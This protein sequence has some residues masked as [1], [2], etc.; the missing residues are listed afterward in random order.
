MKDVELR[1][2]AELMK[3][4]RRNDREL[5]KAIGAS[6]PTVSRTIA[7]LE[8]EGVLKEYTVIPDFAKLG[9]QIMAFTFFNLRKSL[10]PA[11]V[12]E[13]RK[14]AKDDMRAAPSE[15]VIF[16]RGLGLDHD[17]VVV[18]FHRDYSD[19]LEFRKLS[20]R[21]AFLDI[22]NTESFIVDLN[23]KVSY[24]SLTF[25]NLA[26]NVL[27]QKKGNEQARPPGHET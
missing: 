10:T 8:K 7:K 6:Q 11:E 17:D 22:G 13:A 21:Y 19:Y 1:L 5:A 27:E 23:D 24:R 2:V 25:A 14:R 18:S 3:N 4:S 12:L 16:Q 26:M 15:M 9:Y 20:E